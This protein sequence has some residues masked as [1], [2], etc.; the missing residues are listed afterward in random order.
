MAK[1]ASICVVDDD[2]EIR[3]LTARTLES[4]GWSVERFQSGEEFLGERDYEGMECLVLDIRMPVVSGLS[5]QQ[6]LLARGVATPI[7]FISGFAEIPEA[8]E[9]MR[10]GAVDFL[11]K[12]FSAHRLLTAVELAVARSRYLRNRATASREAAALLGELST[13]QRQVLDLL[14]KGLL[15]KQIASELGITER[16]VE[17]HRSA[18]MKKMEVSCIV[19]LARKYQV[20]RLDG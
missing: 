1:R 15:N 2:S 19:E 18:C 17:V 13:R 6:E 20:A 3:S 10:K 8:V 4:A 5:V 11:Q 9:A 7:V 16:T 12:P 14:M